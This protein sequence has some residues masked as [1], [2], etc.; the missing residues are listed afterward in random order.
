MSTGRWKE[1]ELTVPGF[2]AKLVPHWL[3][4][5]AAV[6]NSF[7]HVEPDARTPTRVCARAC[8][9]VCVCAC[10]RA[11]VCACARVCVCVRACVLCGGSAVTG[12]E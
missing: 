1:L 11:C 6:V 12:W 4:H 9:R 7:M 8:A 3:Y 5:Q 2:D 10:A